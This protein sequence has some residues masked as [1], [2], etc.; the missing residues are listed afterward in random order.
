VATKSSDL[1]AAAQLASAATLG[2]VSLVE[3]VHARIAQ[4][5]TLGLSPPTASGGKLPKTRGITGQVYRAVRGVT[6]AVTG[7][8]D[9][10]LAGL[11]SVLQGPEGPDSSALPS[12]ERAAVLAALNGVLGDHL[13]ATGNSLATPMSL[14]LADGNIN[15][16][17][18]T[19]S[20]SALARQL[21]NAGGRLLVL[22]HGLCM[23]DLQWFSPLAADDKK[24]D[25]HLH[26][27][28]IAALCQPQE[29]GGLGY[30]A[31]A[32]RYNSGLHIGT[33]GQ[34][35]AQLLQQLLAAWPQP[36]QR[37][38]VVGHSMGGLVAR[39]AVHQAQSAGLAW[40]QQLTNVVCLGTPH[41][42]APLERAGHGVDRL[43]GATPY[44]APFA[45]L[46]RLRSAGIT[47]LRHG[48]L[49]VGDTASGSSPGP[50]PEEGHVPL[51]TGVRCCAVAATLQASSG[52]TAQDLLGG[53]LDRVLGDGLVPVASALGRGGAGQQSLAFA[54]NDQM[55]LQNTGH[56][57]LLQ[58]EAV[59]AQLQQW[60]A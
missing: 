60:L 46:S 28:L 34:Q 52:K 36:L 21:P 32:L 15:P 43:L 30:T 13:A 35:L 39:S 49:L 47:D 38:A 37:L 2:L 44:S 23:H 59:A 53:V 19:S 10:L 40:A 55:V 14:H 8:V 20:A 51:P 24:A 58:S 12:R 56:L 26:S 42:G 33:S 29:Q 22:V 57:Q 27:P 11:Q 18:D 9:L 41:M 4:T 7:S 31:V 48:R 16:A 45:A 25:T 3:A 50:G 5:A 54:P 1:R 6:G 17:L